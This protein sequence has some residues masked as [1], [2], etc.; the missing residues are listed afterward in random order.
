MEERIIEKITGVYNFIME[1]PNIIYDV[2]KDFY[3]E[4]FVD[5]QNYPSLEEYISLVKGDFS[6]SRIL[7]SGSNLYDSHYFNEIFILVRFPEVRVTNENDRYIDIW[8]LYAK[9]TFNWKG[10][11]RGDFLLNRAE[12]DIFQLQ[13]NYMHSHIHTI[14]TSN[15]TAF[16]SPCLGSGPIRD[17]LVLLAEGFDELR[18]Q[19]FCL[20]LSKYV[21]VESLSGGPYRR[22]ENL[23]K[24]SMQS[25]ENTWAMTDDGN[26]PHFN[27][28]NNERVRQFV[29]WLLERKKLKFDFTNGSYGISMSYITW[30]IFLSNEFIEWYNIQYDEGNTTAT[31]LDLLAEGVLIKGIINNN[32]FYYD[33]NSIGTNY[34]RYAGKKVCTFKGEEVRLVIRDLKSRANDN[35]LSNFINKTLAEYIYRCILRVVNYEYGNNSTETQTAGPSKTVIY[36]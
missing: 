22:M 31:Y 23:G 25:G 12:Y 17:T 29:R 16:Q 21:Q 11:A 3:G 34:T 1:K 9:I 35:N 7:E 14:P 20:E 10:G 4:E 33:R 6:E 19:L 5:M 36:I 26:I 13:N 18:W 32:R 15:F 30:R 27:S 2:F 28:F 24:N 8:E